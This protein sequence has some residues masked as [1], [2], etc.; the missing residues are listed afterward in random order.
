M[1]SDHRY[2][3]RWKVVAACVL[4]V[5][6]LMTGSVLGILKRGSD[7]EAEERLTSLSTHYKHRVTS[8]VSQLKGALSAGTALMLSS[9]TVTQSEWQS[10][11]RT[12]TTQANYPYL[13]VGFLERDTLRLDSWTDSKGPVASPV[14]FSAWNDEPLSGYLKTSSD[15]RKALIIQPARGDTAFPQSD[16]TNH[17]LAIAPV[18]KSRIG[19]TIPSEDEKHLKGWVVVQLSLHQFYSELESTPNNPCRVNFFLDG[20][21]TKPKGK[22]TPL[23]QIKD[24]SLGASWTLQL[25]PGPHYEKN[26]QGLVPLLFTGI[27]GLLLTLGAAG[28]SYTLGAARQHTH[29]L[30]A[31]L[32]RKYRYVLEQS[33]ILEKKVGE[34]ESML[35]TTFN[36]TPIGLMWQQLAP[37]GTI[38]Q[39]A[40]E[41]FYD[42][43]GLTREVD[44]KL[45]TLQAITHGDDLA[46]LDCFLEHLNSGMSNIFTMERRF[47]HPQGQV[48]WTSY[49]LS[50]ERNKDGSIQEIHTL[51]DINRVKQMTSEL[52]QAKDEAEA[53][54]QQL[55]TAIGRAQLSA[56]EANLASHAKS[57]FLATMSHEIRTP[58]NG[59]IGMTSL[60]LETELSA[61]QRDY[62]D[63]IRVSGDSL[64][65]IINDILDYSKIESGRLELENEPLNI[66]EIIESVLDLLAARACEKQIELLMNVASDI[67][68]FV[69]GDCTRVRQILMNLIGNSIKF[70]QSGE[71][72]ILVRLA[73][74]EDLQG[75]GYTRATPG[76]EDIGLAFAIR[77]TGI[78]IDEE[79]MGRLFHSF[80]QVDASTTRKFG[81]SGLGLAISKRLAELMNGRM[82][83]ESTVGVGSVFHFVTLH[84][85]VADSVPPVYGSLGGL[86][87]ILLDDQPRSLALTRDTLRNW[88]VE[89]SAFQ[90]IG[91][92]KADHSGRKP[93]QVAILNLRGSGDHQAQLALALR[94]TP[95]LE[96]I[97]L[98]QVVGYNQR[99]H[100]D[101]KLFSSSL[102]R[103]VME[104]ELHTALSTF[105]PGV[106]PLD[107]D[108][109]KAPLEMLKTSAKERESSLQVD[110]LSVLLVEDNLVNQKVALGML[111]RLGLTADL[112]N[113][114]LEAV[115]AVAL[116]DYHIIFMDMQMPEMNG[117]EASQHIRDT[118]D[119]ARPR[120]WIVALTA[121]AL[122]E[123]RR[124]CIET[125]MDD[126]LS[127]PVKIDD[128]RG[129]LLRSPKQGNATSRTI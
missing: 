122:K 9:D 104:E 2:L 19:T 99:N 68:R 66:R 71:V 41:A 58:M 129:A 33:K 38:N 17:L 110:G 107:T 40:N 82:W 15:R 39:L 93:A 6:L 36:S 51:V 48:I 113:N 125:G 67:P 74:D 60:L 62:V 97:G 25:Y 64:L 120:P 117:L 100:C 5:G 63:T 32:T 121:N 34:G 92:F 128:L 96:S 55:E 90:N 44:L 91:Q 102:F 56:L 103:P 65:T 8:T 78:G 115:K 72:E 43:T 126:Y 59:V 7:R 106:K 4:V 29:E 108:T 69:R 10:F 85:R 12:L 46:R 23:L 76:P 18:F 30:A 109:S 98:I 26:A 111:K 42:I 50:R 24:E 116:R 81:G 53:L 14:S 20:D 21:S 49:T 27:T 75:D 11:A 47:I 84:N 1:P 73:N 83:A 80:S 105:A 16:S 77:D 119:P 61:V 114:G 45:Q 52:M 13:C 37:D 95:G 127:K 112:A 86:S 101:R 54:N 123:F 89:V 124:D 31:R 28:W 35:R 3:N 87:L 88:S 70:T 118:Q 57:A 79:G 94:E 22:P